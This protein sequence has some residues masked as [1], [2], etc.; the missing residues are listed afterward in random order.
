[1]KQVKWT[2]FHDWANL[3]L[4]KL[5]NL[6]NIEPLIKWESSNLNSDPMQKHTV[7]TTFLSIFSVVVYRMYG[8]FKERCY[9]G[10]PG[11]LS[12]WASAFGSGRDPGVLGSSPTSGL[13]LDTLFLPLPMSLPLCV[14]HEWINKILKKKKYGFQSPASPAELKELG[15]SPEDLYFSVSPGNPHNQRETLSSV[16]LRG[17]HWNFIPASL[18]GC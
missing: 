4:D 7:F 1:M 5:S 15:M 12:G 13:P 17:G 3:D 14:S 11:W 6:L 16:S 9:I 8:T 2:T 18:G 10:M